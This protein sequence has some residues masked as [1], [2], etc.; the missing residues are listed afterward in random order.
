MISVE[1]AQR[2]IL[3]R[4]TS[5][6]ASEMVP[7]TQGL[8]RVL[9]SDISSD[10]DIPPF[11]NTSMDGYAVIAQ[12]TGSASP[13]NPVRL[14]VVATIA[15][16]HPVSTP[17]GSGACMRIMTGAPLP[18]AAD[19]VV[20][21]E[22]TRPD[23]AN[24]SF[25]L[26]ERPVESGQNIR[27][28]GDDMKRNTVVLTA[29]TPLTPPV[30]GILATVGCDPVP[31]YRRPRVVIVS[32]GD[33]L[34]EL[35]QPL[36]PG[37]IRNSNSLAM[38]AAV[39]AAGGLPNI[40]PRAHD[41]LPDILARLDQAAETGDV[42]ITSGGVS[43]GDF[44]LVKTALADHGTLDFWQVNMKPGK[45][46]T[47]GAYR[48]RP[49]VGLPGNPVSALVTFE[50][51]VRPILRI[52]QGDNAWRRRHLTLPLGRRFDEVTDRR[53]Y[54]RC[55]L[56][57]RQGDVVIEPHLNQ[58]S[59]IQTSWADVEA[60]MIVPEFTGPYEPGTLMPIMLIG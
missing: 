20:Q 52:L 43:V 27:R 33:E 24:A 6:L 55:R 14:P 16:G 29:G 32:T 17:L 58:G 59:A 1:E 26:I 39:R 11:T 34:I 18:P 23:P 38:A 57:D 5:P 3:S 51:F 60:L 12:D 49:F 41:S 28:Q 54:V 21:V 56:I 7:L 4:V 25:V 37:T 9:S 36:R 13:D 22:W 48:Q 53:H 44:D 47:F 30:I 50:L 15:A 2:R 10:I 35:G 46:V 31:V 19:A 40:L 8:G 42:I 45:P